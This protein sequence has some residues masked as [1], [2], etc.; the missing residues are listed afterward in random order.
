[1]S[2][3]LP[4]VISDPIPTTDPQPTLPTYSINSIPLT[5]DANGEKLLNHNVTTFVRFKIYKRSAIGQALVDTGNLSYSLMD[6]RFAKKIGL[7]T[8]EAP[9]KLKAANGSSIPVVGIARKNVPIFLENIPT[10]LIIRPLVVSGLSFPLNIGSNTLTQNK[11][12]LDF[13]TAPTTL[14]TKGYSTPLET[15]DRPLLQPSLDVRFKKVQ[16]RCREAG[17]REEDHA[18]IYTRLNRPDVDF[19]HSLQDVPPLPEQPSPSEGVFRFMETRYR[20]YNTETLEIPAKTARLCTVSLD[21]L[22]RHHPKNPTIYFAPD[23]NSRA[24]LQKDLLGHEGVYQVIQNTAQVLISNLGDSP[25]I[26]R[27]GTRVGTTRPLGSLEPPL[28]EVNHMGTD[29]CEH[30]TTDEEIEKSID[31][32][33]EPFKSQYNYVKQNLKLK[34]SLSVEYKEKI[35]RLFVHFFDVISTGGNDLG[36]TPLGVCEIKLKPDARPFKSTV[37][38]LN[39]TQVSDLRRQIKEWTEA[40]IIEPCV[41]PWSSPLVPVRKKDSQQFRW[42]ID[43]RKLNMMTVEDVF[44]LPR[45]EETIQ[46]LAGSAVFSCLDSAGAFHAVPMDPASRELTAFCSPLGLYQFKRMGFGLKN[47]PSIYSRIIEKALAHLP[48][49][50]HLSYLD[51]VI[52][53]SPDLDQHIDH[54][55]QVLR[56][57]LLAGMKLKLSKCHIAQEEVTY[58]GHQV[59]KNGVQMMPSYTE[60]ILAWPLPQTPA[61]LR[62]FLGVCG[63]YR[64]FMPDYSTLTSEMEAMKN[65]KTLTWTPVMRAKFQELKRQFS[66]PPIRTFPDFSPS[67]GRFILETDWSKIAKAAVLLQEHPDGIER[68]IG[69]CAHKCSPAEANYSSNKGELAAVIMG[70]RKWEHILSYKPFLI[71]TDSSAVTWLHNMKEHRGMY[72]R[73]LDTLSLFSYQIQHKPG[74]KN[75]FAD[76]LS[77][78]PDHPV[79]A[80]DEDD[81]EILD[82]YHV[83]IQDEVLQEPHPVSQTVTTADWKRFVGK[84]TTLST[85]I[86]RVKSGQ[87]FSK[88][89]KKQ[90]SMEI[91]QYTAKWAQLRVRDDLLYLVEPRPFGRIERLCIPA[92]QFHRVFHWAHKNPYSGHLGEQKTLQRIVDRFYTPHLQARVQEYIHNCVDCLQKRKTAP[93]PTHPPYTRRLTSFGQTIF[94]DLVGPLGISRDGENEYSSVATFLDGYTRYL[95]AVPVKDQTAPT[96]AQALLDHWVAQHGVPLAIH[97]DR[98]SAYTSSLWKTLMSLLGI[99][100]T[101]TPPYTPEA[102]RVERVHRTLGS[103]LRSDSGG[104]PQ[105]WVQK[106]RPASLAYNTMIHRVT[107]VSPYY[108]VFGRQCVLPLDLVMCLPVQAS[109]SEQDRDPTRYTIDLREKFRAIYQYME[110]NQDSYIAR[111]NAR[112]DKTL[113]HQRVDVGDIVYYYSLRAQPGLVRK[114]QRKWLGPY[115]VTRT[116]SPSLVIIR[117][118]D[119]LHDDRYV[120]PAV[121][122]RLVKIDPTKQDEYQAAVEFPTFAEMQDELTDELEYVSSMPD[123]GTQAQSPADWEI[124]YAERTLPSYPDLLDPVAEPL[125]RMPTPQRK[126]VPMEDEVMPPLKDLEERMVQDDD[127]QIEDVPGEDV[128]MPEDSIPSNT[129]VLAPRPPPESIRPVFPAPDQHMHPVFEPDTVDF[130]L[131]PDLPPSPEPDLTPIDYHFRRSIKRLADTQDPSSPPRDVGLRDMRELTTDVSTTAIGHQ[132]RIPL[133]WSPSGSP[134]P[135]PSSRSNR[136]KRQNRRGNQVEIAESSPSSGGRAS[137]WSLPQILP[138]AYKKRTDS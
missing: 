133:T 105:D 53:H 114:L 52:V 98:G 130:P 30:E 131:L 79:E 129:L 118:R 92:D 4:P 48:G 62:S 109:Q 11:V 97:S 73:W 58:L 137:R 59:S 17:V 9:V 61:D 120:V 119:H 15:A 107:G 6:A 102:N 54:L 112:P 135:S 82:V 35:I 65:K 49:H 106:L 12:A 55:R 88:E 18:C 29:D 100:H 111:Q 13:S 23:V 103:L 57:H 38:P 46:K 40:E 64:G 8:T 86:K 136:N 25:T 47:A 10:P 94:I 36:H 39:P 134:S 1:M 63:Y 95:V 113:D 117:P 37:R 31:I 69:A 93:R 108:A 83:D 22:Q 124:R 90:L 132:S 115:V 41:G 89:E 71:R 123:R 33:Q 126:S 84:D 43:Y 50:F 99:H 21:V 68:F 32:T 116:I 128:D 44:P 3:P 34:E 24:L 67:G 110:K 19:V 78:R 14:R 28:T 101:V 72:S 56:A 125:E 96:V 122:N 16:D 91:K 45:L 51:D 121:V 27:A 138:P 2:K 60:R 76:A 26:L 85:V 77:R 5:T 66:N 20:V 70:C 7:E 81:K 104:P 87:P 127:V 74:R 75:V 80:V 42:A